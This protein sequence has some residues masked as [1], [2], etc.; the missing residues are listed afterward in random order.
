MGDMMASW[1][2]PDSVIRLWDI[3]N[4]AIP[5]Q[6]GMPLAGNERIK[7]LVVGPSSVA[8]NQEETILASGGADATI[9]LWDITNPTEP[10]RL[11]LPL[12]QSTDGIINMTFNSD[13]LLASLDYSGNI[14][15]WDLNL[16]S[17]IKTSC[18]IAGRNL[19]RTEA[20]LYL[21]DAKYEEHPTCTAYPV[22][23]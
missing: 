7:G 14:F 22:I 11:G 8:F 21:N 6:L 23:N 15:L 12:D 5:V 16:K 17:W 10:R 3:S 19:T 4:P 2:S 1:G 9:L 20:L 13:G 18:T